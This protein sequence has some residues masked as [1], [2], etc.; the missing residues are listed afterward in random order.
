MID[1]SKNAAD[2][3]SVWFLAQFSV[4]KFR[5]LGALDASK[6]SAFLL[7][8]LLQACRMTELSWNKPFTKMK[9]RKK[10]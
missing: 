4:Y 3:H 10:K 1:G 2:A 5:L 8:S 9:E 6:W 7:E